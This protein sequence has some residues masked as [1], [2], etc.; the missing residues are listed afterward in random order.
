M[1]GGNPPPLA[2]WLVDFKPLETAC[3]NLGIIHAIWVPA[4]ERI[5]LSKDAPAVT[6]HCWVSW[7]FTVQRNAF[8]PPG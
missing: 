4:P 2:N 7:I 8:S 1:P 3:A 5:F 6:S